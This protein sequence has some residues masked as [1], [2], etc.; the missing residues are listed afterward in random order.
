M[1]K[2]KAIRAPVRIAVLKLGMMTLNKALV[3]LQPKSWYR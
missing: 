2:V 1:D 3:G